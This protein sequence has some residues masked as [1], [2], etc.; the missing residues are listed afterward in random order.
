MRLRASRP[1]GTATAVAQDAPQETG[2][3][4]RRRGRRSPGDPI[5]RR[6]QGGGE[7][8]EEPPLRR[9]PQSINLL[10]Y[11]IDRYFGENREGVKK[12]A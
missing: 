2:R 7:S 12:N 1:A 9:E 3:D 11:W 6:L 5:E 8:A 4:R 10:T